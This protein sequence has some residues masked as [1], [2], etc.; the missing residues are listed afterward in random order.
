VDG[1]LFSQSLVTSAATRWL[2]GGRIP[3]QLARPFVP[4][5][6]ADDAD[7]TDIVRFYPQPAQSAVLL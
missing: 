4:V 3:S 2:A 1:A 5:L 7:F 6:T